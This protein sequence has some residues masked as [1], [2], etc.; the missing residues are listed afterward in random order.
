MTLRYPG[1][2]AA[3]S[4]LGLLL[5]LASPL[6]AELHGHLAWLLDLAVHWQW[7]YLTGL[8]L[9]CLLGVWRDRRWLLLLLATPLPWL[10]A[11]PQLPPGD[12][13]ELRVASANVHLH[14]R[15]IA[16]LA[17]WLAQRQVDLLILL[18]V[19][20]DYAEALQQLP[21]YKYRLIHAERSPF[22]IALLSRL[23]L[24][25]PQVVA[26][27]RGIVHLQAHLRFAG[28]TLQVTAL[29]PMP[30]LSPLD[31]ARRDQQLQQQLGQTLPGLLAGDLNATPWSSAFTGL[32]D[33][34][35]R[36]ASGL[37]GTWP[38]FAAGL[39]GIPIDHILA[40]QHWH[41]RGHER[42]P[43]LGSDHLPVLARLALP[44]CTKPGT[45][46]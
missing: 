17:R 38:S 43:G 18:E 28:C 37:A 44:A 6:Q 20:P 9:A 42:G 34:G 24:E 22:G 2:L 46:R 32:A 3:V 39:L 15:D 23:P 27:A 29:H 4:L 30:P 40:S 13:S 41:L 36:R 35:W 31:H 8:L 45:A 19:S 1:P 33:R 26:D 11:A 5:P 14:N 21:G 10:T 25:D 12:G 16:P 7:L